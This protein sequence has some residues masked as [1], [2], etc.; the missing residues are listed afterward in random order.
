MWTHQR[1]KIGPKSRQNFSFFFFGK[2]NSNGAPHSI[3]IVMRDALL[4]HTSLTYTQGHW[5]AGEKIL[6][7]K[8]ILNGLVRL[9]VR[10][11]VFVGPKDDGMM[12]LGGFFARRA[13][14]HE[15]CEWRR[16]EAAFIACKD[17]CS[18]IDDALSCGKLGEKK[19]LR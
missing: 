9:C 7:K 16:E 14:V 18:K 2:C 3:G 6:I 15:P 10:M 12:R 19:N 5:K 8:L 17:R 1:E 13:Q 4:S 11:C